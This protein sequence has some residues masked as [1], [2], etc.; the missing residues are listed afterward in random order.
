MS[1]SELIILNNEGL[2]PGRSC[3]ILDDESKFQRAVV[4]EMTGINGNVSLFLVDRG[5]FLTRNQFTTDFKVL[6]SEF[7][8]EPTL[9]ST[10]FHYL[11][12]YFYLLFHL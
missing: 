4:A 8:I 11:N 2:Y 9:V 6:L 10:N 1:D 7:A 5:V 12:N 3:V